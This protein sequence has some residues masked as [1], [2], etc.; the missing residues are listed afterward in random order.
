MG[1]TT[2]VITEGCRED[3]RSPTTNLTN[4][5]YLIS[6]LG[7]FLFKVAFLTLYTSSE[8]FLFSKM[9]NGRATIFQGKYIYEKIYLILGEMVSMKGVAI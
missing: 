6:A 3:L 9:A 1:T 5:A 8:V 4:F 2:F 7:H